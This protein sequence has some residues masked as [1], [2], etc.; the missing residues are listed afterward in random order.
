[1]ETSYEI[2]NLINQGK[3]VGTCKN[4]FFFHITTGE[5]IKKSAIFHAQIMADFWTIIKGVFY[6]PPTVFPI[7]KAFFYRKQ[8]TVDREK[9]VLEIMRIFSE[10]ADLEDPISLCNFC[11]RFSLYDETV[12]IFETPR[13]ITLL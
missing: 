13:H 12:S 9:K 3:N 4:P 1:M 2:P 11:A 6:V 7:L 5:R 10:E 8:S